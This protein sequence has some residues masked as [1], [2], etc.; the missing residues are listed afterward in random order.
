MINNLSVLS[1]VV[2]LEQ[3]TYLR[4]ADSQTPGPVVVCKICINHTYTYR[5]GQDKCR[6]AL[7]PTEATMLVLFMDSRAAQLS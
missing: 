5:W 2:Q 4:N 1:E 3:N 6:S 7:C